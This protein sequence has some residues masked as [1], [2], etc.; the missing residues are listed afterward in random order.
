MKRLINDDEQMHNVNILYQKVNS[1]MTS[2]QL[3]KINA[4]REAE[5]LK[6]EIQ[7]KSGFLS[8]GGEL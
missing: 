3:E 2:E 5:D 8:K 7:L 6:R 1:S 4:Y